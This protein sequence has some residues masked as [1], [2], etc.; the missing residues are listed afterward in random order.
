MRNM[1]DLGLSRGVVRVLIH[2]EP[3]FTMP[4]VGNLWTT[5][6]TSLSHSKYH[7]VCLRDPAS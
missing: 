5:P 2:I 4:V 7:F 3:E 6:N 1:G